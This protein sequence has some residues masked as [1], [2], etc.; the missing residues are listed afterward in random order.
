MAFYSHGAG[1]GGG[2]LPPAWVG[3]WAAAAARGLSGDV[4]TRYASVDCASAEVGVF[5]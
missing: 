5:I 4:P 1:E 3:E 2:D